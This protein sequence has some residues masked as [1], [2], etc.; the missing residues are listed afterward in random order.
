MGSFVDLQATDGFSFPAYVAQ[1]TGPAKGAVV[2]LQE[3]FG[4]NSHIRSVADGYA[5]EGYLAV[6]P[7]TF[8]RVKPGVELGYSQDD[9]SAGFALKTAV[10]ALPAPGVLQD[11]QAAIRHAE[12]A[13]KVGIVGYCW[14]GLLT[15]RSACTLDGLSA[16]VCYYGGGMTTPDEAARQSKVPT[17]A[18]FGEKD[19]WIPL[20]SV[21]AFRKA[22]PEVEVHVYKADHGFNCD[23]RASHDA[24][25]AK[26][27]RERTVAFFAKH[28]A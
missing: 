18:H 19:H 9:M 23:Q 22:H 2:V 1:P 7:S 27:A 11:I 26:L 16:A 4:V 24:T 3:I 8:H 6:A 5:N 25:A 12:Q 15:W 20:E 28:L 10:E 21:E 14:G 17:M 13:G